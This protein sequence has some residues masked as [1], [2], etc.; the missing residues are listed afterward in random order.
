MHL[1]LLDD[2]MNVPLQ[3]FKFDR[4]EHNVAQVGE[5]SCNLTDARE[6]AGVTESPLILSL[7]K[8]GIFYYA[9]TVPGHCEAGM[10]LTVEVTGAMC[11]LP[12][13]EGCCMVVKHIL[14][15]RQNQ[16]AIHIL[17]LLR[18]LHTDVKKKPLT[19]I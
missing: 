1:S 2:F 8:T 4:G 18:A 5:P 19:A 15:R 17:S 9:C 7:P 12:T 10:L 14:V 16:H 6:L 13:S 3:V 11:Q